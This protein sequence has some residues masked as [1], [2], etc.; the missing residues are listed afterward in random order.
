MPESPADRGERVD[1]GAITC[2]VLN[3]VAQMDH[4]CASKSG[5]VLNELVPSA[6]TRLVILPSGHV[7]IMSG[8]DA[9]K[10]QWPTIGDWLL[11]R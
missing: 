5:P 6:D 3:I 9:K 4:I 11:A 1:L 7:G 10:Y 2:A 8:T